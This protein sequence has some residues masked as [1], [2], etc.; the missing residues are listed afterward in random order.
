M[1][2]KDGNIIAKDYGIGIKP[3]AQHFHVKGHENAGWGM[4]ARILK[5]DA[6]DM[7]G[8]AL[9]ANTWVANSLKYNPLGRSL[10]D[11][12]EAARW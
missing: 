11:Y 5:R 7:V 10:S 8:K 6:N 12:E 9:A 3:P 1:A 2:D 4:K